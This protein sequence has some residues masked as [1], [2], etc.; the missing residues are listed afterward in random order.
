MIDPTQVQ[1]FLAG[2]RIAVVGASDDT[3][4]FGGTIYRELVKRGYDAIPVNPNTTVVDGRPCYPTVIAVPG[5]LD[6]VMVVVRRE[7]AADVVRDCVE[8]GVGRVWL[9]KGIGAP[10]AVS[11]EAVQ[12]CHD[13]GIEVIEGACPLMFLD[14]V[15]AFHRVHRVM[16]RMNRSL[17]KVG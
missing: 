1:A 6:G 16:R 13:H 12:L 9:F 8:R 3:K 2:T 5:E 14:P 7:L 17:A 11:D 15:G 4:K 10:G